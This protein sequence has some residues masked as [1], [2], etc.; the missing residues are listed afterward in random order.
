[1]FKVFC[2][3]LIISLI[4]CEKKSAEKAESSFQLELVDSI[5]VAHLGEMMLLDISPNGKYLLTADYQKNRYYLVD[6]EGSIMHTYDKSGDQPDSF[7][8]A[9]SEMAF[10]DD[11]SIFV[12]GSKGLKWFN[13][14]GEELK[15]TPFNP[16]YQLK[17]IMRNTGG[18]PK[19]LNTAEGNKILYR[20]GAIAGKRTEGGYYEKIRGGVLIDP[21]DFTLQHLFPL[22]K[23]SRFFDGKHYDDG[24]LYSRMAV[25]LD[26][27]YVTY[28]ANPV[29]YAYAKEAPY[30][31]QFK[32]SLVLKDVLLSEGMPE[33]FLDYDVYIEASKGG[34]R[35]LQA[36]SKYVYLMY[37]QGISK[38]K[39]AE[40]DQLYEV[41]E[42]K[43]DAAYELEVTKAAKRLKV[44]DLE[45]DEL[46]D[47]PLPMYL[48][49][50]WG[51]LV[52]DGVLYFNKATNLEEEEDFYTLYM[53][54]VLK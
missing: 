18:G 19:V 8:F 46:A 35:H 34:L 25:G 22:D 11:E 45:G 20:G 44:F 2:V 1:M 26:Y 49:S 16:A 23:E 52:R 12:I 53:L 41:D 9:F 14:E 3:F 36:D 7:G 27:I 24:D 17:G 42:K 4:A 38:E 21:D 33:E 29:L 43:A 50:Y 40:L 30:A 51:F 37:F 48:D 6:E 39:L 10:W 5:R 31:L 15:F 54:R 32:K 28:D 13:L 47:I